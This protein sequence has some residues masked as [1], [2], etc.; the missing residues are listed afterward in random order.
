MAPTVII[1]GEVREG[2]RRSVSVFD[3]G[4]LFGD[5]VYEVVRT[6]GGKLFELLPHLKRLRRSAAE[7]YLELPFT[8]DELAAEIERATAIA[9][10]AESYVRIIVTRGTGELELSPASC[11][12]PCRILIVKALVLPPERLYREGVHLAIVD[13]RR[14]HPHSLNPAAK[15]GNYLNNVLAIVEAK[16]RGADDAVMRN[17]DGYLTEGTTSNLFMVRGGK[18]RTPSLA[19]G[20][21]EGITRG[22]VLRMLAE[23]GFPAE[24]TLVGP[25]ELRE[26]DEAFV[27]STTRDVMPVGRVDD[28]PL[29]GPL[30]GPVTRRLMERFAALSP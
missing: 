26:A 29:P 30:P 27:T 15:T 11:G 6:R 19:S 25:E 10:N 21:L 22:L 1:D 14:M 12:P 18:V 2:D 16:K 13:R 23:E 5:S 9:G 8:D 28:R 4:F 24:E 7:I 20:I 3:H 17:D